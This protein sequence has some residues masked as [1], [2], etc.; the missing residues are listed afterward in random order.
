MFTFKKAYAVCKETSP[1]VDASIMEVEMSLQ[2]A[3]QFV[4]LFP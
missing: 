1:F 4:V 3:I 2:Q